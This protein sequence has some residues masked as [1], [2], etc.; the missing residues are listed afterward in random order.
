MYQ[1]CI[2]F[3]QKII[4]E[5]PIILSVQA[6]VGGFVSGE[7]LRKGSKILA[8]DGSIMEVADLPEVLEKRGKVV[9]HTEKA[10]FLGF[11]SK[12]QSAISE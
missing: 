1:K 5:H 4:K 8:A 11:C 3:Q 10:K 7:D 2:G 12:T 9:L 6:A